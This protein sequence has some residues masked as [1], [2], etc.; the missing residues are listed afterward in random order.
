MPEQERDMRHTVITIA[1]A[2]FVIEACSL[3]GAEYTYLGEMGGLQ[4]PWG[5]AAGQ[6]GSAYVTDYWGHTVTKYPT[7]GGS[8]AFGGEFGS[9]DGPA[10]IALDAAG[11]LYVADQSNNRIRKMDASGV[12][13][14]F[15][16]VSTNYLRGLA[17]S[18]F[19]DVYAVDYGGNNVLRYNSSGM[20]LEHLVGGSSLNKPN[21]VAIGP[22]G[23]IYVADCLNY[24]VRMY[25]SDGMF[26]KS[27]GTQGTGA[28][29]F[30]LPTGI[31]VNPT[32]GN[33]YV[34][35]ADNNRVMIF[36]KSGGYIDQFGTAGAGPKQFQRPWD[37]AVSATGEIYVTDQNNGR[38]QRFAGPKA[39][40]SGAPAY[41]WYHGCGPT[42]AASIFGYYDLKGYT[43][44]FAASGPDVYQTAYVYEEISSTAHNEKYD[45]TPD[46]T[47]LPAPNPTSIADWFRTSVDPLDY[48]GSYFSD[49]IAAF[50]GFADYKGY[51]FSATNEW[52]SPSDTWDHLV[53]EITKGRPVYFLVDSDGDGNSDHYVP[54]IGYDDRGADG[55]WYACYRTTLDGEAE[56][57]NWQPFQGAGN[58]WGIVGI[59]IVDPGPIPEPASLSLLALGGLA[60][61]R[62][63]RR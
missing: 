22:D 30:A 17:V 16:S 37:V 59:T 24:C 35:D 36:D 44:L 11:N 54:V 9:G 33:V 49:A 62:G 13:S 29:Q 19:G 46:R 12:W 55:R 41:A 45:P 56:E 20:Y 60:I 34:A 52:F 7:S 6:D 51:A 18:N 42:A 38:V 48:G 14:T 47:D 25:N 21:D 58:A 15:A 3:Y 4:S 28:N 10:G 8:I 1:L 2:V 50:E 43:N 63:R 39:V 32:T 26:L 61:L 23:S 31:G 27:W 5:V 57:E 53:A 40:L